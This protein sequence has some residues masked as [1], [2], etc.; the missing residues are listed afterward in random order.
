MKS[1]Y[2]KRKNSVLRVMGEGNPKA[3]NTNYDRYIYFGILSLIITYVVYY[4]IVKF[5]YIRA[6]GHVLYDDVKIRLTDD[7]RIIKFFRHEGD[8]ICRGD[9]LFTYLPDQQNEAGGTGLSLSGL[10]VTSYA[11]QADWIDK[12]IY[13]LEKKIALNKIEISEQ[14][15][16]L[17]MYKADLKRVKNE[18][19]LDALPHSRLESTQNEI[20]R[21]HSAISKL[22]QENSQLNGLIKKLRDIAKDYNPVKRSV[23]LSSLTSAGGNGDGDGE[24]QVFYSPIDGII[25]RVFLS[26]FE[27]ALRQDDILSVQRK[28][29]IYVK[30]YFEQEDMDYFKEGDTLDL[31]FPD[32]TK[33]RGYI[34]RFYFG[35]Y[36]LPEEF[37][38]RYEPL[39][40]TIAADILPA[41]KAEE[42]RWKVYNK[43]S[44]E[45]VKY[46]Y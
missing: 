11:N 5:L 22:N 39:K 41:S 24:V 33:S 18:V 34:K 15:S 40:R 8:S 43:L 14:T 9:T 2:F 38:K 3:R 17:K 16:M 7:S 6:D 12:E 19:T 30:A 37:Q 44:V 45:I 20:A 26:D 32:G 13:N 4:L 21:A 29:R 35:T 25:N 42:Q 28:S 31:K 46:K 27:V 23:N 1:I 36:P 10:G